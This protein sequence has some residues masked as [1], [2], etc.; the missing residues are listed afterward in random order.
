MILTDSPKDAIP[1]SATIAPDGQIMV[2]PDNQGQN[3]AMV[4]TDKRT[5]T[6][7]GPGI[8]GGKIEKTKNLKVVQLDGHRD[9]FLDGVQV[10]AA[11]SG[12]GGGGFAV[13]PAAPSGLGG[14][15][16]TISPAPHRGAPSGMGGGGFG[17]TAPQGGFG[18]GGGIE[19]P[20][21][22]GRRGGTRI[23]IQAPQAEGIGGGSGI[24]T[25][26]DVD[27][28]N[29]S[30][31]TARFK[32]VNLREALTELFNAAKVNYTIKSSVSYNNVVTC[33]FNHASLQDILRAML[34]SVDQALTYR[35]D[36]GT[37]IISAK[38]SAPERAGN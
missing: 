27:A 3:G 35:V 25:G 34:D 16:L 33:G 5:F 19:A 28:I 29:E 22:L 20:A 36:G 21:P 17:I 8:S 6:L 23:T 15:G 12:M 37:Y 11:P 13:A 1:E 26:L 14:G 4:T 31:I 38:D 10:K 18:G 9:Y 2:L 32:N 30:N 7:V 24:D